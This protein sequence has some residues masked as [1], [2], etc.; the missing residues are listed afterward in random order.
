MNEADL[1][2]GDQFNL[3]PNI[4][5]MSFC[6]SF[7]FHVISEGLFIWKPG[8]PDLRDSPASE[9]SI[10]DFECRILPQLSVM[11]LFQCVRPQI[12]FTV[13]SALAHINT[14]MNMLTFILKAKKS[15]RN[16]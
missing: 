5:P 2:M 8:W 6:E 10:G 14:E 3:Q 12:E 15:L 7:P 16:T 9:I 4:S 13:D 11:F 1:T